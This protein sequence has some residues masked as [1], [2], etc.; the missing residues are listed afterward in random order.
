MCSIG[1]LAFRSHSI[2]EAHDGVRVSDINPLRMI[3]VGIE[4]NAKGWCSPRE[5]GGFFWIPFRVHA[6]E[7]LDLAGFAFGEEEVAVGCEANE[8][9]LSRPVV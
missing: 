8:R 9:G 6:A 1:P 3:A 7:D 5:D 2:R 4:R